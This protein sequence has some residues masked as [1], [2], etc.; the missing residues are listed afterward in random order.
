MPTPSR[1]LSP[2]E[3]LYSN[4][5]AAPVT[6]RYSAIRFWPPTFNVS[7]GVPVTATVWLNVTVTSMGSSTA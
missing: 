3:T 5:T 7:R 6:L 4:L 2:R 1:S